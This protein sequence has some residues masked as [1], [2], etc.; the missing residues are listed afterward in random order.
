M[1]SFNI[2]SAIWKRSFTEIF[3]R[4]FVQAVEGK[5]VQDISRWKCAN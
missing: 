4:G 2:R 3:L 1:N 5:C